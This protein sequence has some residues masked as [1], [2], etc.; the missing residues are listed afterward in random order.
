MSETTVGDRIK[1]KRLALGMSQAELAKRSGLK[2]P[3]ISSLELN[4]ASN[5]RA[6]A[7]IA[8]ALQVNALWL[9]KG[10][11]DPREMMKGTVKQPALEVMEFEQM[12]DSFFIEI[13]ESR[14]SCGGGDPTKQRDVDD[15]IRSLSPIRKDQAFFASAG[16]EPTDVK[17]IVADGDGMANFIV[18][19]DTVL[20]TT[21]H[22]EKLLPGVIYA[23]STPDGIAIKRVLR[24]SDGRI[25][26]AC[27]NPDK[28]RYPDE[29]F[30]AKE[31]ENLQIFGRF[32][33]RE[34]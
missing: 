16:V 31:A 13:V 32:L 3:T 26:L 14:G 24:R 18:H 19:G 1:E 11:G 20:V 4:Q 15:I 30:S 12:L 9:E 7:S 17:A 34:G 23:I 6:I 28:N 29:E 2:Q 5:T 21:S 22:C 27:D 33:R 8:H 25:I 10:E